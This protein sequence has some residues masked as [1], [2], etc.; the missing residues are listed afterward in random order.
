MAKRRYVYDW[1]DERC[2]LPRARSVG[3][4]HPTESRGALSPCN[5][6]L[7]PLPIPTAAAASTTSPATPPVAQTPPPANSKP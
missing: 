6:N 5:A 4:S 7:R 2:Y 3:L 1:T